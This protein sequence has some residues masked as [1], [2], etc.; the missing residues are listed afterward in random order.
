LLT[1]RIL[2]LLMA[3]RFTTTQ[4]TDE[5]IPYLYRNQQCNH[6][7]PTF[8]SAMRNLTIDLCGDPLSFIW[9]VFLLEG[10]IDCI[11]RCWC[12]ISTRAIQCHACRTAV[13]DLITD[14]C[15]PNLKLCRH[16]T[17][18]SADCRT[19]GSNAEKKQCE[20]AEAAIGARCSLLRQNP[21]CSRVLYISDRTVVSIIFKRAT[22]YSNRCLSDFLQSPSM[23]PR[24]LGWSALVFQ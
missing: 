18:R 20:R 13:S 14:S 11:V 16:Q 8:E 10:T 1:V 2:R 22:V 5:T 15:N 6:S 19:C 23:S 9:L 17:G 7:V 3:T 24:P 4:A 21:L 12:E